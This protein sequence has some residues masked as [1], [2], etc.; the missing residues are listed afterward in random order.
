MKATEEAATSGNVIQVVIKN[1]PLSP[2]GEGTSPAL[3]VEVVDPS[4]RN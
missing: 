2:E 1:F 4:R 3:P